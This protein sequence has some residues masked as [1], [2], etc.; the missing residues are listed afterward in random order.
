VREEIRWNSRPEFEDGKSHV[1][2]DEL[3]GVMAFYY[4]YRVLKVS[5]GRSAELILNA[6]ELFK[7]WVN[8]RLAWE[9]VA[10][11]KSETGAASFP[12]P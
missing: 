7:V 2:V 6:D 8:G 10:K 12:S 1:F 9:Q 5:A 3:H 11:P 4:F